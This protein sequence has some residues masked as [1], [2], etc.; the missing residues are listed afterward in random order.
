MRCWSELTSVIICLTTSAASCLSHSDRNRIALPLP[1]QGWIHALPAGHDIH[2]SA[3]E[4]LNSV[5]K[6]HEGKGI[7][8]IEDH[9][10][11]HVAAGVC[12]IAGEG[13]KQG[14]GLN[15]IKVAPLLLLMR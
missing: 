14:D 9:A 6:V 4:L 12:L 7:G 8:R 11:I 10:E 15:A 2:S 1:Q 5:A 13:T 3:Q